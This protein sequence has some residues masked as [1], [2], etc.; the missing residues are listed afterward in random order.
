MHSRRNF[1]QV[2]AGTLSLAWTEPGGV[3]PAEASTAP[4]PGV[5]AGEPGPLF[6]GEL[7]LFRWQEF[8][9]A[10]YKAPVTGIIYRIQRGSWECYPGEPAGPR[11]VSGVP[12]GGID[13]GGLYLE[14][15]GTIGY[16]SI[17]NHYS[18]PG[19]PINTP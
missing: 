2:A 17:F 5:A 3:A 7:A 6:P 15:P 16:S 19:G 1:L 13:T 14:G 12:L 10:G 4:E 18:P 9:A 11:P 8:R